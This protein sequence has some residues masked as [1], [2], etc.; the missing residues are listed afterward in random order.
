M[1]DRCWFEFYV[2]KCHLRRNSYEWLW[3]FL[4]RLCM[5]PEACYIITFIGDGLRFR[6]LDLKALAFL[7]YYP[8][9]R[10]VFTD[11]EVINLFKSALGRNQA[12]CNCWATNNDV[13]DFTS[14]REN[15][16]MIYSGM[17]M[18]QLQNYAYCVSPQAEHD[19]D[20]CG[21]DSLE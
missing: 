11:K 6:I 4:F 3:S 19:D 20:F 9:D 17:N 1:F 5:N 8:N 12:I 15:E 18:E 21:S 2:G 10:Y 14:L 7:Y 13:Y 16:M